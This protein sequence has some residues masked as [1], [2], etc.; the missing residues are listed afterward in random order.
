LTLRLSV[1]IHALTLPLLLHPSHASPARSALTALTAPGSALAA[2]ERHTYTIRATLATHTGTTAL[3]THTAHTGSTALATHT[4]HAGTAAHAALTAHTGPTG[5]ALAALTTHA[6]H[7][8]TLGNLLVDPGFQSHFFAIVQHAVM[9]GIETSLQTL[10]AQLSLLRIVGVNALCALS[11]G[12]TTITLPLSAHASAHHLPLT[13][14]TGLSVLPLTH[15]TTRGITRTT[16][17]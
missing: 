3:A 14:T 12:A 7:L 9:I 13:K 10:F 15:A 11:T 8:S 5:H 16:L 17:T 4:A 2:N 1:G 6:A